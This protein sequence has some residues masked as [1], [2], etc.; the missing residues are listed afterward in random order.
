MLTYSAIALFFLVLFVRRK[1]I[2]TFSMLAFSA[3]LVS[4]M[5]VNAVLFLAIMFIG[6]FILDY[7]S[8]SKTI[9]ENAKVLKNGYSNTTALFI[10]LMFA[11]SITPE[12]VY[13]NSQYYQGSYI[14]AGST[15]PDTC[16]I[17]PSMTASSTLNLRNFEYNLCANAYFWF[18]YYQSQYV[19]QPIFFTILAIIGAISMLF[20]KRKELAFLALWF[21]TF[22]VIYTA[23]YAGS[24]VFG[25]NWRFML[26]LI[27]PVC[28]AGGYGCASL[29][30]LANSIFKKLTKKI[31]QLKNSNLAASAATFVILLLIFYSTYATIPFVGVNPANLP[32]AG[33][34]RYYENFVLNQSSAIPSNC[35]VYSYD[36]TLFFLVNRSALQMSYIQNKTVFANVSKQ[37]SCQVVDY[38][39]WCYTPNSFCPSLNSPLG[40]KPIITST[41]S[42]LAKTFGFSYLTNASARQ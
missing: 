32:Q 19:I 25:I 42:P 41:Y 23:F 5:K 38:G 6:Y 1:N 4:Y 12:I 33:D 34:A 40:L 10:L 3:A 30:T 29:I 27:A 14:Y 16:N 22:F 13:A 18:N 2:K 8:I 15:V 36:P 24:V 20:N 35:I 39:Y 21:V 17:L 9:K 37:Y 31:K 11:I 26:S 7:K 28:I